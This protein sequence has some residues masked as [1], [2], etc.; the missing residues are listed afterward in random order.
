MTDDRVAAS[1]VPPIAPGES[2]GAMLRA[3]RQAQGLHLETLANIVKVPAKKLDALENDRM[4]DLHDAAFARAL[5]QTVAR[6]LKIDPK[7]VLDRLPQGRQ[8]SIERVANG[9]NAPFREHAMRGDSP[10]LALFQRP[11]VWGALVFAAAAA[12]LFVWPVK[13]SLPES[14]LPSAGVPAASA[15]DGSA[16]AASAVDATGPAAA[17]QEAAP[18]PAVVVDT[19]H[20]APPE[21]AASEAASPVSD[22]VVV[23]HVSAE[24]WIE[25]LDRNGQSLL[26][27]TL[28]PGESVGI[29]G[30]LPLRVKI[31]NAAATTLSFRG[32]PVNLSPV[33][34][35]NIAR[36]ELR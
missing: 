11:L 21:A 20:S 30:A 10:M 3:A 33:T 22:A 36:L 24:S 7:A 1:I 9:L 6:A 28:A 15:P 5:A 34:R 29:D 8:H 17:A 31:G 4:A 26:A 2:A 12:A 23:L 27:R 18:A 19:V 35:D 13:W 25:V 16:Q 14:L 32:D